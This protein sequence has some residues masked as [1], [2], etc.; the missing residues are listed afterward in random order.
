M[1]GFRGLFGPPRDPP[2]AGRN[3]SGPIKVLEPLPKKEKSPTSTMGS[4]GERIPQSSGSDPGSEW[5]WV[6]DRASQTSQ[7]LVYRATLSPYNETRD[8]KGKSRYFTPI[9]GLKGPLQFSS[10]LHSWTLGRGFPILLNE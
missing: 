2:H 8:S 3:V 4:F 10:L 6:L 1:S 7:L 9:F 5:S